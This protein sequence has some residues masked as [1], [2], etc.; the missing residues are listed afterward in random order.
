LK[1]NFEDEEYDEVN[2]LNDF[3]GIYYGD[4]Y[5][6]RYYEAGA[7]FRYAD[8]CNRLERIVISLAPERRGKSMYEDWGHQKEIILKARK[9]DGNIIQLILTT[10]F[11]SCAKTKANSRK[12][13]SDN[14]QVYIY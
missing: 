8:L 3:K 2:D 6:Q 13:A 11:S 4:N 7:H 1:S 9:S 10:D 5:E 14:S 12:Y